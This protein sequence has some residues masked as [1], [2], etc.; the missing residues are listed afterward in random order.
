MKTLLTLLL[1]SI[2]L[3]GY[4][5]KAYIHHIDGEKYH[6][7][8][9]FEPIPLKEYRWN[10]VKINAGLTASIVCAGIGDG[11]FDEGEKELSKWF[12][13]ASV[14][15]LLITPFLADMEMNQFMHYIIK[16]SFIRFGIFNYT[17]NKTRGLPYDYLGT[18]SAQDRVLKKYNE[19][20]V[21]ST[22]VLVTSVGFV[23]P[24]ETKAKKKKQSYSSDIYQKNLLG[25]YE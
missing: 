9:D 1:I 22:R 25:W 15:A 23:L 6:L 16:Y 12:T 3:I 24:I 21:T 10:I 19:T 13:G 11:L 7:N 20:L 5:Q 8:Q 4:S 18:T 14:G 2:C 17:Y